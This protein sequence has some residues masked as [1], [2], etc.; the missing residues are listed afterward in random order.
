[1]GQSAKR[2][3]GILSLSIAL[4]IIVAAVGSIACQGREAGSPPTPTPTPS[5]IPRISIEEVKAKLDTGANIVIVDTRMKDLYEG[6]HI[7]GAISIPEAETAQRASEL[8]GYDEV[9]IY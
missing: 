3:C 6:R 9:L 4:A 2:C 1:M 7:A 8:S 5:E